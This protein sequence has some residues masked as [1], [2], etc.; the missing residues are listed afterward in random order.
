MQFIFSRRTY[1]ASEKVF[2][3]GVSAR[4][5]YI[6]VPNGELARREHFK[7]YE[8]NV[9]AWLTEVRDTAAGRPVVVFTHGFNSLQDK[10]RAR[11]A[12]IQ[13]GLEAAGFPCLV[14]LFD[15]P[16]DGNPLG[17]LFDRRD[18]RQ[19]A[20]SFIADGIMQLR[21]VTPRAKLHLVTHSM[22]AY[23]AMK[24][25]GAIRNFDDRLAIQEG[26]FV[27]SD[28]DQAVMGSGGEGQV[29]ASRWFARFTNYY[30]SLDQVLDLQTGLISGSLRAGYDGCP[31]ATDPAFD[32]VYCGAQYT[33]KVPDGEKGMIPSHSFYWSDPGFYQDL[34]MTLRGAPRSP[35]PTRRG[36]HGR[37]GDVAL[38][39]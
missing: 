12:L 34:A 15:W 27:A 6:K 16:S 18:A 37:P 22:G 21:R 35:R 20:S 5:R 10:A 32:D 1:D 9:E 14:V 25:F 7:D 30:S 31:A 3:W 38:L 2:K 17:Y 23:L 28:I 13:A 19:V 8:G 33:A 24:A 26:V 36:L 4:M 39:T 11:M 29:A